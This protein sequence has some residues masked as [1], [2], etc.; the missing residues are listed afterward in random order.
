MKKS[1]KILIAV[2][3]LIALA[4]V[5][6]A[7]IPAFAQKKKADEKIVIDTTELC[8]DV[9]GHHAAT[10]VEITV[11]GRKIQ[12]VVALPSDETPYFFEQAVKVL[13]AFNGMTVKEALQADVDAISGATMSS[14]A[15]I[16][17]VKT[18]LKTLQ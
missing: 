18:G 11:V 7:V 12:S 5:V 15:L 17:N 1:S 13:D 9:L 2:V 4:S 14:E 16:T 10:P 6:F 8:K 3:A